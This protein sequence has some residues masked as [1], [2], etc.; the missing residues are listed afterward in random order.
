MLK[1]KY[2]FETGIRNLL[3]DVEFML[4]R[5]TSVYWKT[6][7]AVVTPLILIVIFFYTVATLSPLTYSGRAYPTSAHAAGIVL[8]CFSVFQ[9][10]LWMIVEMIKN[11]HLPLLEVLCV[12]YIM[13]SLILIFKNSLTKLIVT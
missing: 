13:F 6:C 3:D 8:L 11:R 1:E 2:L 9:I 5:K 10:P 4:D 12:I 7:W